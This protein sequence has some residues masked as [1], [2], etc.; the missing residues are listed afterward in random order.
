M[1]AVLSK[2]FSTYLPPPGKVVMSD[3]GAEQGDPLGSLYCAVVFATVCKWV[4]ERLAPSDSGQA[5][6]P[7]YWDT[8]YMDD[9][10]VICKPDL[11]DTYL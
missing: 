2:S 3:C 10:Q 11:V 9:G 8:W 4:H 1:D 7:E 5:E 6:E